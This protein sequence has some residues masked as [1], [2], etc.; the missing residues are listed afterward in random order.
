MAYAQDTIISANAASV[1]AGVLNGLLTT[2]GWTVVETLT[3]SGTNSPNT[4]VYKSAAADNECGY[5]WYL[6]LMWKGTGTEA[7]VQIIVGGAYNAGTHNI[8]QIPAGLSPVQQAG[9]VKY[10]EAVTGDMWGAYNVNVATDTVTTTVPPRSSTTNQ[11]KPWFAVIVPSSAFGYWASVTL[12]HFSVFTTVPG[13]FFAGTLDLD[14]DWVGL[15]G[16]GNGQ[17]L[18]PIVAFVQNSTPNTNEF[19]GISALVKG[20]T[21][22]PT[23]ANQLTPAGRFAKFVG[24]KLPALTGNYLPA[25]AWRL[26]AYLQTL[27][28]GSASSGGT[29]SY[30]NAGVGDGLHI[31]DGIDYYM[32][33]GGSIGDTVEI[34]GG[35]YVLSGQMTGNTSPDTQTAIYVAVLV[36]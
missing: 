4:K 6:A 25:Y 21:G 8:S 35:T 14:A 9:G 28:A 12:D 30:D 15:T 20:S 23:A 27:S 17:C 7:Q 26:A 34:E 18:N 31:G 29:P 32:V 3:P 16:F 2:A 33:Y 1:F 22:T 36:E 10:A 24:A 19:S 5:D 11:N 13:S